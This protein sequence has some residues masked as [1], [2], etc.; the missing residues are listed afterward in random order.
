MYLFSTEHLQMSHKRKHADATDAA[1][2]DE[3]AALPIE[4][5]A[6]AEPA[7]EPWTPQVGDVVTSEAGVEMTV[8]QLAVPGEDADTVHCKWHC[9]DRN[10][11]RIQAFRLH[12]LTLA[13][14]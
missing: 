5:I 10:G 7:P 6:S 12:E 1:T 13:R 9:K 11:E 2:S 14:H 8:H 4:I 3:A